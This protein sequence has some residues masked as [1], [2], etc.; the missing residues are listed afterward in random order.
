MLHP[1]MTSQLHGGVTIKPTADWVT[2]TGICHTAGHLCHDVAGCLWIMD[3][4]IT[5]LPACKI[6][7]M[8][9]V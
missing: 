1:P 6:V 9:A 2:V 8:E 5:E 7:A 4:G 3:D